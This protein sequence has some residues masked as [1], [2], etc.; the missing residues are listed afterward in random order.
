VVTDVPLEANEA[1]VTDKVKKKGAWIL[2]QK[3]LF[4]SYPPAI[5][6]RQYVSGERLSYLGRHYRL[7]VHKG[8]VRAIKL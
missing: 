7:K 2:K 1:E 6:A 3:R 5:P 8:N 4:A